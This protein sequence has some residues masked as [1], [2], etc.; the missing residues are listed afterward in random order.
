MFFK[1][2]FSFS[3]GKNIT[4]AFHFYQNYT[5]GYEEVSHRIDGVYVFCQ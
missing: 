5:T 2:L 3:K 4:F 1:K